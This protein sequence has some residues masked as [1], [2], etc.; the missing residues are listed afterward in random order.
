MEW[1]T[2]FPTSVVESVLERQEVRYMNGLRKITEVRLAR[3]RSSAVSEHANATEH[4]PLW[5]K[6]KFTDCD[7]H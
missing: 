3:A 6:V 1:S 2:R 7:P 5:D 4:Y